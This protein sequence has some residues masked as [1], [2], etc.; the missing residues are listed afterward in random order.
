MQSHAA[1]SCGSSVE[2]GGASLQESLSAVPLPIFPP[3][4][5]PE[6]EE[7]G[8]GSPCN[9]KGKYKA[10]THKAG[11]AGRQGSRRKA[12]GKRKGGGNL[13][14]WLPLRPTDGF[15]DFTPPADPASPSQP[16]PSPATISYE[17]NKVAHDYE[18]GVHGVTI[19][20]RQHRDP[21]YRTVPDLED[22]FNGVVVKDL[23][24]LDLEETFNGVV[25]KDLTNPDLEDTF[26]GVV[27]KDLTN[28]DLEETFNGVVVKDLTNPDLEDTFNGVVVKDLMNLDLEETFNGVVVKD[29]A[30][31]D[32]E[33]TF[34]PPV[35]EVRLLFYSKN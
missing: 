20:P 11:S 1:E 8:G 26:N 13:L 21:P 6:E 4:Y 7:V 35:S 10:H 9:L 31:P 33:K 14:S 15:W 34:K 28:I 18:M 17:G 22:T 24:N 19:A 27:V 2:G 16:D 12:A 32:L 5:A 3:A 30:T 29:L 23:T 25:V